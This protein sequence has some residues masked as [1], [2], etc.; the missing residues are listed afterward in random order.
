MTVRLKE[1]DDYQSFEGGL[2]RGAFEVASRLTTE[3]YE[4]I[5]IS[6]L[7]VGRLREDDLVPILDQ[8]RGDA[9]ELRR[10]MLGQSTDDENEEWI[11]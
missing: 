3:D 8:V 10:A 5:P 4:D 6:R 1:V 7:T 2:L 9:D 11:A